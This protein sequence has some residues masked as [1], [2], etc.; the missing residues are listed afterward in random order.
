MVDSSMH[1]KCE[2]DANDFYRNWPEIPPIV[3]PIHVN[4][5]LLYLYTCQLI[6]SVN[7]PAQDDP[8]PTVQCCSNS[9]SCYSI[10][11]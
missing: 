6:E 9:C 4:E 10:T 8:V 5:H 3:P 2:C 7:V 11:P 1:T